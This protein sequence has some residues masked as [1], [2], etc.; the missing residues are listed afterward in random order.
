MESPEKKGEQKAT[1]TPNT[2]TEIVQSKTQDI[3][4][5]SKSQSQSNDNEDPAKQVQ[6]KKKKMPK[7]R[8]TRNG[9]GFELISPSMIQ[10]DKTFRS[11][12]I[13]YSDSNEKNTK[14]LKD[15]RKRSYRC[16]QDDE[17]N[18]TPMEMDSISHVLHP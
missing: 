14:P 2:V 15:S 11:D 12:S 4:D 3:D 8:E 17:T 5:A 1:A 13:T 16:K 6:E 9:K 7:K 10:A 18:H